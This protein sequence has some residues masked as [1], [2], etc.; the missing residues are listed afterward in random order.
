MISLFAQGELLDQETTMTKHAKILAL[1]FAA[2]SSIALS[3]TA[4]ADGPAVSAVNGKFSLEGGN[5]DGKSGQAMQGTIAAPIGN[6]FGVQFDTAFGN[7]NSKDFSGYG[8]HAFWRDPAR[9]LVGLTGSATRFDNLDVRRFGAEA[10]GYFGDFTLRAR[11]GHQN[12]DFKD[13]SYYSAGARWYAN[14]NLMLGIAGEH[15]VDRSIGHL[16]AEWQISI[17]SLPGLAVF[18]DAAKGSNSFDQT[19]VGVRYYFGTDKT[20]IRRHRQDDPDSLLGDSL[21]SNQQQYRQ[22][23]QAAAASATGPAVCPPMSV[24]C[25]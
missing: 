15:A 18:L 9:G 16:T 3:S 1:A 10:E 20:L 25:I 23:Q 21:I 13:G 22:R 7:T 19:L 11:A 6:A 2:A 14:S 5:F 4:L 12:G 8:A 24:V 17:P